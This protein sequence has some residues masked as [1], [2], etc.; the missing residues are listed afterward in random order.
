[1]GV[2][3]LGIVENMGSFVCP[4]CG[5]ATSI[6]GDGGGQRMAA[7]LGVPFLGSVPIDPAV[8]SGGDE[9]KPITVAA[10]DSPAGKAL[11]AIACDVAARISVMNLQK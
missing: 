4:H 6:F 8:R 1:V 10:P 5:T 11:G 2:P 3:I 7:R 9:G